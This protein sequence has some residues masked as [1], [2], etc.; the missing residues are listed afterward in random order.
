MALTQKDT[1]NHNIH[2]L[3]SKVKMRGE[4]V[5]LRLPNVSN[6]VPKKSKAK[7]VQYLPYWKLEE[8]FRQMSSSA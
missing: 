8:T 7:N 1:N 3:V 4:D 6:V 2:Y 5:W